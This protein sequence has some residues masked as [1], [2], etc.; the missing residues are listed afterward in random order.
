[1]QILYEMSVTEHLGLGFGFTI[2]TY[3]REV[4]SQSLRKTY[5]SLDPPPNKS[6]N[7]HLHTFIGNPKVHKNWRASHIIIEKRT[8]I[9]IK[10]RLAHRLSDWAGA[11][12]REFDYRTE[13]IFVWSTC[14]F[15]GL[16][17]LFMCV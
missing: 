7:L 15:S 6:K 10:H 16:G 3:R 1:M 13:Q 14:N 8:G 4:A 2:L 17:C 12:Y 5:V 9:F 11:A